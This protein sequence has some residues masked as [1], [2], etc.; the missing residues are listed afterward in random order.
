[1]RDI[2]TFDSW[3]DSMKTMPEPVNSFESGRHE[4]GTSLVEVL[5]SIAVSAIVGLALSQS[6]T[7]GYSLLRDARERALV[8]QVVT[9]A[10]EELSLSDPRALSARTYSEQISRKGALVH[11]TVTIAS[12]ADG[13]KSVDVSGHIEDSTGKRRA[14]ASMNARLTSWSAS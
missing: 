11:R 1:M 2:D 10:I 9:S 14:L 3:S 5:V 7:V 4:R 8:Q 12:N 13:S 6:S